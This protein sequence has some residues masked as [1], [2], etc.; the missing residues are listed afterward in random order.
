MTPLEPAGAIMS[1]ANDMAQ[2]M[3]FNLRNGTTDNGHQLIANHLLQ[4]AFQ[5]INFKIN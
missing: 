4:E 1:S 3:R 2:W 5:V